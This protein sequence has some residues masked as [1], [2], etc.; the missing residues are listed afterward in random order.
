MKNRKDHYV[1]T[2]PEYAMFKLAV[3][4]HDP[5][6][7]SKAAISFQ[8]PCSGQIF[9]QAS[10]FGND[11]L[12]AAFE[13][14]LAHT[15]KFAVS[16]YANTLKSYES[17]KER[18][19]R[20]SR[21]TTHTQRY[22]ERTLAQI[23]SEQETLAVVKKALMAAHSVVNKADQTDEGAMFPFKELLEAR[24]FTVTHFRKQAHIPY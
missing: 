7:I 5:S 4:P 22:Y 3:R 15:A 16:L 17:L 10:G 21:D 13:D 20:L 2:H 1:V 9:G 23:S 18:S 14:A 12:R 8:F 19:A 6:C 11:Y 24:G